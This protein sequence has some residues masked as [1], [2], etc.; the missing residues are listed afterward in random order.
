[1]MIKSKKLGKIQIAVI[2][3]A[4]FCVCYILFEYQASTW[5][6]KDITE[7]SGATTKGSSACQDKNEKIWINEK[8]RDC[9][10][11]GTWKKGRCHGEA[12]IHCPVTC[13]MCDEMKTKDGEYL[14]TDEIDEEDDLSTTD[15]DDEN[16]ESGEEEDDDDNYDDVSLQEFIDINKR[17]TS[18]PENSAQG[19]GT[20]IIYNLN[21][22]CECGCFRSPVK[23]CPRLYELSDVIQSSN[24]RMTKEISNYIDFTLQKRKRL[25]QAACQMEDEDEKTDSPGPDHTD[26]GGYCLQKHSPGES[27]NHTLTYPYSKR[28]VAVPFGHVNAPSFILE[29]LEK[30]IQV[31]QKENNVMSL[32]DFGAGIGQ[33]GAHL[34]EKFSDSLIYKGY[35]GAGDVEDYTHGYLRFFDLTIPLNLPRTDW[36]LCLEVGEHIPYNYEGMMV[37]NLHAHNCKGIILSWGIEGQHGQNHV[38]LHNNDYIIKVFEELGYLYDEKQT[39]KFRTAVPN[40]KPSGFWFRNSLI[41]LRRKDPVC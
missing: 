23:S 6:E 1:M 28:K 39:V 35:D 14:S 27:S 30:F 15:Y 13:G 41:V 11:V 8:N 5:I 10:W 4:I 40:G 19:E 25:S 16:N 38:N 24:V 29:E 7:V 21:K 33:Y 32:S 20:V 36:I 3:A 26:S 22:E 34:E 2:S 12:K 9:S 17:L 18:Y 31:E 37:R